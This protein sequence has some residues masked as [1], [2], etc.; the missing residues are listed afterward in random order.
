MNWLVKFL[1]KQ[2]AFPDAYISTTPADV[3]IGIGTDVSPDGRSCSPQS[4]A[5]A[6]RVLLLFRAG[7]A[8][9]VLLV[10]G[11]Q[12]K[13]GGLI[14]A[15]AMAN[16]IGHELPEGS[17]YLE[18]FSRNTRQ[19]AEF[20][21]EIM[22]EHGWQYAI[23]VAQPVHA[24]RVSRTFRKLWMEHCDCLTL[25]HCRVVTAPSEYGGGS[26]RRWGSFLSFFIWDRIIA[27]PFFKLKGWI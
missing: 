3:V 4:A 23:I 14:E 15:M 10:G 2:I 24:L 25:V 8:K 26:Q 16:R 21:L 11:N 7:C 1:E 18:C 17:L 12:A 19:N 13:Y 22:K 27:M 6:D 5:I 9:N 20:S